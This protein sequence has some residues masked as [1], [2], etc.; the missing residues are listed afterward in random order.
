MSRQEIR[1]KSGSTR[2]LIRAGVAA[3]LL[4]AIL[5]MILLFF[6]P[7]LVLL[8][9]KSKLGFVSARLDVSTICSSDDA[10]APQSRQIASNQTCSAPPNG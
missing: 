9:V 1:W 5:L 10:G 7:L 2:S 6:W 8:V 3:R 4:M